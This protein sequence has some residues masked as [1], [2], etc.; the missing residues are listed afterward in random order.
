[1]SIKIHST[2]CKK[3]TLQVPHTHTVVIMTV[4]PVINTCFFAVYVK[5]MERS[6]IKPASTHVSRSCSKDKITQEP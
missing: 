2:F 5:I 3:L 1:M 4:L 6:N